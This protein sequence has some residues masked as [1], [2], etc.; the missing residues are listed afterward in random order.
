VA[1]PNVEHRRND[2]LQY[3][4]KNTRI[5]DRGKEML[6]SIRRQTIC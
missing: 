2:W 6:D 3:K 1:W 4:L 5:Y